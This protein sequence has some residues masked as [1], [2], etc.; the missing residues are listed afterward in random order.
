MQQN[1]HLLYLKYNI[2]LIERGDKKMYGKM[3]EARDIDSNGIWDDGHK[4]RDLLKTA[5]QIPEELCELDKQDVEY[6]LFLIKANDYISYCPE[7]NQKLEDEFIIIVF[8]TVRLLP[9]KCCNMMLWY[10]ENKI[11]T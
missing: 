4:K 7:C 6:G 10:V 3:M 8:E 9:V 2:N 5:I 11:N 1:L